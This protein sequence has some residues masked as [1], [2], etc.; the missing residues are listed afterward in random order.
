MDEPV[1]STKSS[2]YAKTFLLTLQK[3]NKAIEKSNN[4]LMLYTSVHLLKQLENQKD[5]CMISCTYWDTHLPQNP[6]C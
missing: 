2:Q 4:K 3:S 6:F 5:N 1:E